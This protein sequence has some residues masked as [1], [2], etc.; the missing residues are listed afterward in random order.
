MT[1][2]TTATLSTESELNYS[3]PC[4]ESWGS[5]GIPVL[6]KRREMR[7]ATCEVVEVY[8][9]D[10]N[11][12]HLSG[13]V[14]AISNSG[15]HIELDMPLKPGDR[16]EVLL[17]NMA[18]VFGEVRY[19]RS[20]GAPY[21]VATRI[22]DVYYPKQVPSRI[23][24]PDCSERALKEAFYKI[25]MVEKRPA[26][27]SVRPRLGSCSE[28]IMRSD[29]VVDDMQRL[30]PPSNATSLAAHLNHCDIENLL[31]LRLSETKAALLERHLVS[32]DH[33][34]DLVLLAL[35]ERAAVS[36]TGY[37]TAFSSSR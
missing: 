4:S 21:H 25:R 10:R 24:N 16:V 22:D 37:L 11:N 35:E 27:L 13:V 6:E 14:R 36:V 7:Y 2:E 8:L 33:C 34:L 9:L 29:G 31:R 32:C 28:G 23:S 18:I 15:M 3:S 30:P 1:T 26:D 12:L 17:Q 5:K 19:C 20:S